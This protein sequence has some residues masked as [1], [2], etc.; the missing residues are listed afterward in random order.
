MSDKKERNCS[1]CK[2]SATIHDGEGLV[3][4]HKSRFNKEVLRNTI[5]GFYLPKNPR[6][7]FE[8]KTQIMK[9]EIEE[10]F[11][12]LEKEQYRRK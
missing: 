11:K 6:T 4:K 5:C 1:T 2:F 10:E 7:E 8:D 9:W 3:C 12:N